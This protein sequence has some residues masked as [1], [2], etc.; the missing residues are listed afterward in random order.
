V[1]PLLKAFLGFT[2]SLIALAVVWAIIWT[3][4]RH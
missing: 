1:N 4:L 2:A 3:A